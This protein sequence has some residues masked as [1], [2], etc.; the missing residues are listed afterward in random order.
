MIFRSLPSILRLT[1]APFIGGALLVTAHGGGREKVEGEITL[2]KAYDRALAT[3][4]SIRVAYFATF[5]C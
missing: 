5:A 3:D 1:I 4:Q 2:E